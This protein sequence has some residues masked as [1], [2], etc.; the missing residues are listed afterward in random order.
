MYTMIRN[1]RSY[2]NCRCH[3]LFQ[4]PHKSENDIW[5]QNKIFVLL[6][7]KFYFKWTLDSNSGK[8]CSDFKYNILQAAIVQYLL[9][10][11]NLNL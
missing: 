4:N 7:E 8:V 3:S 2:A 11:T 9:G 1:I 6:L 10:S 5:R